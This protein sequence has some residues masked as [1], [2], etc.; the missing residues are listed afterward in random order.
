MCE[1]AKNDVTSAPSNAASHGAEMATPR[2]REGQNFEV[3][4]SC[5]FSTRS[6]IALFFHHC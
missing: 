6:S 1:L 4:F 3:V 5:A 2:R